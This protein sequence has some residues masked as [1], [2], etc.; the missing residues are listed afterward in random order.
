[1]KLT[2]QL[3]SAAAL[4]LIALLV[5]AGSIFAGLPSYPIE[6]EDMRLRIDDERLRVVPGA[7]PLDA[8]VQSA[9][10]P[11]ERNPFNLEAE[12]QRYQ[13]SIPMPPAP[14]LELPM[15]PPMPIAEGQR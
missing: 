8:L 14:Q 2:P 12:R 6:H 9:A 15:P 4:L 13:V 10:G 3:L 11:R 1:V 7:V 5:C